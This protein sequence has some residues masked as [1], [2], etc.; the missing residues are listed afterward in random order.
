VTSQLEQKRNHLSK[1]LFLTY[2]LVR[3]I[4][5]VSRITGVSKKIIS[6][7]KKKGDWD[8]KMN[9]S[10]TKEIANTAYDLIGIDGKDRDSLDTITELE[11]LCLDTMRGDNTFDYDLKPTSFDE[12]MK[13]LKTCWDAKEKILARRLRITDHTQIGPVKV[14]FLYAA[15]QETEDKLLEA[16]KAKKS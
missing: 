6:R 3:S 13:G 1:A 14:D 12:A 16:N 15:A 5:A 9:D 11:M 2:F 4:A 10:N 7:E 8:N